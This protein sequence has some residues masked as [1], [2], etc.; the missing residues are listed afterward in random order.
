MRSWLAEMSSWSRDL[1]HRERPLTLPVSVG[2]LFS[3]SSLPLNFQ[4]CLLPN[5]LFDTYCSLL[6]FYQLLQYLHQIIV[7]WIFIF[8]FR[9]VLVSSLL[10]RCRLLFPLFVYLIVV[11]FFCVTKVWIFIFVLGWTTISH[12]N[13]LSLLCRFS[14]LMIVVEICLFS[15]F[16]FIGSALD[17]IGFWTIL[18]FIFI[19]FGFDRL[20]SWLLCSC[21]RSHAKIYILNPKRLQL[22]SLGNKILS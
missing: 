4:A 9:F 19:R 3:L 6:H 8:C 2:R 20:F 1:L 13:L 18:R 15:V 11:K 10:K 7:T 5:P 14:F 17:G 12:W 21:A 16:R 22:Y